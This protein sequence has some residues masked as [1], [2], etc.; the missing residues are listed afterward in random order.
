MDVKEDNQ[1]SQGIMDW[2][3][4]EEILGGIRIRIDKCKNF[5]D[6]GIHVDPSRNI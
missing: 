5:F 6:M 2:I 4:N 3:S 1:K